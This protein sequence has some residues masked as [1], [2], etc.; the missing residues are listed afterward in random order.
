MLCSS[1]SQPSSPLLL[2]LSLP[3]LLES[4]DLTPPQLLPAPLGLQAPSIMRIGRSIDVEEGIHLSLALGLVRVAT[5]FV[6]LLELSGEP[7]EV[8]RDGI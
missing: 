1:I 5:G 6:A 7:V 8:R 4:L 2:L 3:L